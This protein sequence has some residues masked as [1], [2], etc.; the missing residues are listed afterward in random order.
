MAE[1]EE[2]GRSHFSEDPF[3]DRLR[4]KLSKKTHLF[5]GFHAV[6]R[7]GFFVNRGSTI[8]N[9]VS[10]IIV[11]LIGFWLTGARAQPIWETL[12]GLAKDI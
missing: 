1:T 6:S 9:R 3:L 7:C 4:P 11:L 2:G 12:P 10:T 5:L 8:V